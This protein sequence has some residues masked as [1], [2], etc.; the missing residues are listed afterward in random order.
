[1]SLIRTTRRSGRTLIVLGA[2]GAAFFWL[3]DP[4]LGPEVSNQRRPA[5]DPRAWATTL[6]GGT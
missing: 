6:R 2:V 5:Y 3:T 1:M 4:R